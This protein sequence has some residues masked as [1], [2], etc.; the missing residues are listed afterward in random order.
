MAAQHR[1]SLVSDRLAGSLLG[2]V[3]QLAHGSLKQ[4]W[5]KFPFHPDRFVAGFVEA[6]GE[7]GVVI[8]LDDPGHSQRDRM[9]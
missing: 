7:Q 8:L 3:G 1:T 5:H 9:L 2:I 6:L 4:L